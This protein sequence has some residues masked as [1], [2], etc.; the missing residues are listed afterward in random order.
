M[1]LPEDLKDFHPS[2]SNEPEISFAAGVFII[3]LLIVAILET[4]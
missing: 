3:V 2:E 4:A 1:T